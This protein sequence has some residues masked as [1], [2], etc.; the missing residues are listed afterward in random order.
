MNEIEPDYIRIRRDFFLLKVA[1]FT[2]LVRNSCFGRL[3]SGCENQK[4]KHGSDGLCIQDGSYLCWKA[5][6][7]D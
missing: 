3:Y 7:W 4:A 2:L 1:C 6:G 5:G